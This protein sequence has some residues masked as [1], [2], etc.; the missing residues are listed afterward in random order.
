MGNEL[1]ILRPANTTEDNAWVKYPPYMLGERASTGWGCD[2]R[3][4]GQR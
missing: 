3:I 2:V 1:P 4:G